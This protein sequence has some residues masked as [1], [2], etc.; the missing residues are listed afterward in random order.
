MILKVGIPL[1]LVVSV[2]VTLI[3]LMKLFFSKGSEKKADKVYRVY[4]IVHET[5][6]TAAKK[7]EEH[8]R[9]TDRYAENKK[10]SIILHTIFSL[11][12]KILTAISPDKQIISNASDLIEETYSTLDNAKEKAIKIGSRGGQEAENAKEV[13]QIID[14][15]CAEIAGMLQGS[16][17]SSPSQIISRLK[18]IMN[19]AKEI[20]EAETFINAKDGSEEGNDAGSHGGTGNHPGMKNFYDIL[21]IPRNASDDEIKKAY[22]Y[23]VHAHHPDKFPEGSDSKKKAEE[24][25]KEINEAYSTLKDPAKRK[26]YDKTL[27]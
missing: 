15:Y 8:M 17:N 9:H 13:L 21:E 27:G 23:M 19:D 10:Q 7:A 12:D 4:K 25:I 11:A 3:L 6:Q 16:E 1:L 2:F 18:V 26:E 20:A 24:K 14:D 22:R 5:A